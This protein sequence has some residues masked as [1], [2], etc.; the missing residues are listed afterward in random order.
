[1]S[2][3]IKIFAVLVFLCALVLSLS[4]YS[5]S[6]RISD[7]LDN[8]TLNIVFVPNETEETEEVDKK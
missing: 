2:L 7:S 3:E 6:R 5:A 1:M 8:L 4:I